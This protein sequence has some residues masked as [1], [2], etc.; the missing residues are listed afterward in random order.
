M[1]RNIYVTSDQHLFHDNVLKFTNNE[2]SPIRP[3]FTDIDH[4]N[5]TILDNWNSVVKPGD[6]VYHLGDVVMGRPEGFQSFF[7]K[8][9]GSKRLIVG[10]HD[11]I[12]WLAPMG[13][14][15]KVT[16]WRMFIEYGML[17]THVPVHESSLNRG[18]KKLLNVHGHIHHNNSPMGNYVNLCVEKTN[19]TPVHI[20]AIPELWKEQQRIYE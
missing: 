9:H 1:A 17:F 12:K 4:M 14:F 5:Q 16:M 15:Q 3:G 19:Y 13:I 8:F 6:I 10:N 11:E 2:G 20:D 18:D 7:N